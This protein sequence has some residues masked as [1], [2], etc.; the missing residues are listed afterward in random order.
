[1]QI[2][3]MPNQ[4]TTL[5]RKPLGAVL[6]EGRLVDRKWLKSREF[7]RPLVDYYLRS[8]A[9]EAVARGIYRRPGPALKWQH[10]V[11]SLQELGFA[12]HIGGRTALDHQGMAHYLP[13]GGH[14]TIQLY[15]AGKLPA[16]FAQLETPVEFERHSRAL[17][18]ANVTTAGY[19][20]LPFGGWDWPLNYSTRER[21]LLEYVDELPDRADLDMADKYMEGATSF[22][23]ELLMSLLQ[24]CKRIKTKRLFLWLAARH[25]HAWFAQLDVSALELGSGKRVVYPG[26]VLDKQYN[27]TVPREYANGEKPDGTG[28]PL[29]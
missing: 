20:S 6:P 23:P 2:R 8:G 9:L 15:A 27:I 28:Q 26:G 3:E 19:T 17:F 13:M 16:W 25:R 1:M 5:E 29:F 24:A 4:Y 10:V 21:A 12:I 14:E 22:R 18:A 7:N 11:Y